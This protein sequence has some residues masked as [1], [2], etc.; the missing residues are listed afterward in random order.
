MVALNDAPIQVGD[1]TSPW[2]DPKSWDT[3]TVGALS[4]Y[5]KFEIHRARRLYDWDVK[6]GP[7]LEGATQTYRGKKPQAFEIAFYIW[8]DLMWTNWKAFSL[9]FQYSGIKGLVIPVDV[10]HPSLNQIGISQ[11]QCD[12]LGVLERVGDD[13]MWTV[14]VGIRE[15]FPPLPLNATTTPAGAATTSPVGTPGVVPNPA[16]AALQA[17]I[18]ALQAQASALG[19]PGGLP[20]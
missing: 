2:V 12:Y 15:Y 9:Q 10:V 5:G 20:P 13:G 3:I 18:A 8:T 4:W 1:L 7:G 17:K 19:T 14:P 11:I 6:R 16:I